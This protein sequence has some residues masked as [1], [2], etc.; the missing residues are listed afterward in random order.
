MVTVILGLSLCSTTAI[1][2]ASAAKRS[3]LSHTMCRH[4]ADGQI[5]GE[6][7]R[8]FLHTDE[9]AIVWFRIEYSERETARVEV[10][11]CEPNGRIYDSSKWGGIEIEAGSIRTFWASI[12]IRGKAVEG[13]RG[14]WRVEV[15]HDGELLFTEKFTIGPFYEVEV[16]VQGLPAEYS[17]PLTVDGES[18]GTIRGGG[19]KLIGFA[20]GTAHSI[21]VRAEVLFRAGTRY[22][23]SDSSQIVFSEGSIM[24]KYDLQHSLDAR[25]DPSGVVEIS[26]V[27]WYSPGSIATVEDVP[28]IVDVSAVTRWVLVEWLINGVPTQQRPSSIRM[29]SSHQIVARY[30]KQHYLKVNSEFGD[31]RGEGWY[32]EGTTA[33][34]SVTTPSGFFFQQV[35]ASWIGDTSTTSPQGKIIIDGPR[36]VT[37]QWRTD[38]TRLY[39]AVAAS[40]GAI[41]GLVVATIYR[42]RREEVASTMISTRD[43]S[44][45]NNSLAC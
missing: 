29:D 33:E 36:T 45:R 30:R 14:Y 4:V 12:D 1:R 24:F 44:N 17:I 28:N 2:D 20:P 8:S 43:P 3:L 25:T 39:V 5:V 10:D 22:Y 42:R 7:T 38:H 41:I 13:K 40:V 27:G 11:W 37:A 21:E 31:P 35:L 6:E 26:G 32:D 16:F 34:F 18:W 19:R 23:A 15:S 9:R